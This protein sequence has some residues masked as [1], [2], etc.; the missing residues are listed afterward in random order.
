M[1]NKIIIEGIIESYRWASNSTGFFVTIKQNRMFGKTKFTDY[2]TLYANKPLANELEN[3]VKEYETITVEGSLRTYQD[4]KN[5]QWK[6]AIE[7]SKIL[8][9]N[10]T[11]E[12]GG[13]NEQ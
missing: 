6:S 12:L 1:L 5:K 9:S 10:S 13:T 2:F 7:V 4:H 11:K 3:H 8:V